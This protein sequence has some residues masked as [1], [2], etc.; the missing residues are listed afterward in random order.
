MG[1]LNLIDEKQL[2]QGIDEKLQQA[3]FRLRFQIKILNQMVAALKYDDSESSTTLTT[4]NVM[5]DT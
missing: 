5:D 4:K 3:K 2:L 1:R